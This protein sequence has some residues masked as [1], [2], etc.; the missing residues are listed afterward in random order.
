MLVP[1][2]IVFTS[3]I[4][5][6]FIRVFNHY[7]ETARMIE[8]LFVHLLINYIETIHRCVSCVVS[9]FYNTIAFNKN[10]T[11]ILRQQRGV[12]SSGA[13]LFAQLYQLTPLFGSARPKLS[14]N[15]DSQQDQLSKGSNSR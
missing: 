9:L 7:L 13:F 12:R 4:F 2:V 10:T 11:A 5:R 1:A 15:P 3:K 6:A 14:P 8:P